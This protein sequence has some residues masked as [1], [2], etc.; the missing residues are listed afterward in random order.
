MSWFLFLYS[1]FTL[2]YWVAEAEVGHLL[3]IAP[4]LF[5]ACN[6]ILFTVYE[7]YKNYIIKIEAVIFSVLI[8]C[9]LV[10]QAYGYY[11][12]YS[13]ATD[14]RLL[15]NK[16]YEFYPS[17]RE[18][19]RIFSTHKVYDWNFEMAK[20]KSTMDPLYFE[21]SVDLI[22]KYENEN[23]LEERNLLLDILHNRE[24]THFHYFHFSL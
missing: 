4:I 16:H 15:N 14:Q 13:L 8:F 24:Y 11:N 18:Y 12:Y 23:F 20:F 3:S 9:S 17:I 5:F 7:E 19:D 1:Q 22:K 6:F 21:Q 10:Y 2:F